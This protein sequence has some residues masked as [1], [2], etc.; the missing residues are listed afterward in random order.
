P[1]AE[2]LSSLSAPGPQ[3]GLVVDEERRALLV[4]QLH[5]VDAA[6]RQVAVCGDA[7]RIRQQAARERGAHIESGALTPSKPSPMARPTRLAST[8]HSRACVSSGLTSM[9]IT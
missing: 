6:H 4:R 3:M 9:P 7:G 8:S 2:G 1:V 5:E